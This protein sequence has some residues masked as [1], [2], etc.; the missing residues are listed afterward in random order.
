M[1]TETEKLMPTSS[2]EPETNSLDEKNHPGCDGMN[3]QGYKR[4]RG[5]NKEFTD[6]RGNIHK[7]IFAAELNC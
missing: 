5:H 3:Q 6:I 4:G 7:S 1:P 2:Q